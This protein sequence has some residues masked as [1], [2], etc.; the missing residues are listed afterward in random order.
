VGDQLMI[1][2]Q[3]HNI[4]SERLAETPQPIAW[5][6]QPG[7]I[8]HTRQTA[9]KIAFSTAADVFPQAP[10]VPASCFGIAGDRI[11]GEKDWPA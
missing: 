5:E 6:A 1:E 3:V 8:G 9:E 7:T 4:L 11:I 10:A 2:A